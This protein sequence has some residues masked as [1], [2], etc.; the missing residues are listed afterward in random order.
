MTIEFNINLYEGEEEEVLKA[1]E[2]LSHKTTKS[3]ATYR[4][5]EPLSIS[6]LADE[7]GKNVNRTRYILDELL[8][9]D[10]IKKIVVKGNNRYYKRYRYEVN[11]F[12]ATDNQK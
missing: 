9:E 5:K 8:K 6:K 1:I 11:D 2:K 12:E 7:L 3:G 10:K 4:L